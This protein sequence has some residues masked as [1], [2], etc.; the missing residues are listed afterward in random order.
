MKMNEKC[1]PC[2]INQV[3]KVANITKATHKEELY[4]KVFQY[5]SHID[6]TKSNP[7]IIGMTFEIL[8]Q[9]IH[10][11]DPYK[12][13]RYHYNHLMLDHLDKLKHMIQQS[14]NPFEE[15]IKYAT[16]GNIIDFNPMHRIDMNEIMTSFG[17]IH[18]I[19]LT[20]NDCH[21]L[22][23]D[24]INAKVLLYLGDN[25][26]EICLDKIF[27]EHI[28]KLNPHIKIYFG[29]RG[30]A[31][32]NDSIEEDAYDVKM[33][34]Y[35]III[36]NGDQS[37]GT[38]L[39]RTS[40]EFQNVYHQADVIISKGQANYE[41]LSEEKENIYFLLMVKCE[42][43]SQYIDVPIQSMICMKNKLCQE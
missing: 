43:I 7:E 10:N 12:D 5:L 40:Q 31:V 39:S 24:I 23:D 16:L 21:Q 1:L 11:D 34:E 20:I 13:I 38:V 18:Q 33:D 4:Q 6:F 28:K 32:V 8:K 27:I 3:V 29:V 2:L 36:S 35:A 14:S 26:G 9:H 15:A 37:L 22:K 42:V 19:D 25:C 30:T 17:N 41:S